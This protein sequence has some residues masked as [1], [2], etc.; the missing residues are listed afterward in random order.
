MRNDKTNIPDHALLERLSVNIARRRNVLGLTQA[1]LAERLGV[2]S[3]TISRFERGRHAPSLFTLQRL[4]SLLFTTAGDLLD[5]V[6]RELDDDAVAISCWLAELAPED[7]AFVRGL[8]KEWC[9]YLATRNKLP[10]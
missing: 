1:Q 9:D 5:E 2:D 8:L 7:H 10:S 6:P 3:E 4:A